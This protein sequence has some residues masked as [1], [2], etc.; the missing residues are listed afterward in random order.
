MNSS[1]ISASGTPPV[2]T[3]S[4]GPDDIIDDG[5][6]GFLVDRND[7]AALADRMMRI[8]SDRS[9]NLRL[10]ENAR[11]K[12]ERRYSEQIAAKA[13]VEVFDKLLDQQKDR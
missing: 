8:T 9:L 6:D 7:A 10:S 3:R 13:F 11:R 1:A 5:E 4:G 12:V 2:S